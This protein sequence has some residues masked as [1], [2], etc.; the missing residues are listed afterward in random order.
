MKKK[1]KQATPEQKIVLKILPE[2]FIVTTSFLAEQFHTTT[3]TIRWK[4]PKRIDVFNL[5]A[6]L[7]ILSDNLQRL[8]KLYQLEGAQVTTVIPNSLSP[9]KVVAIPLNLNTSA[10]KKEY[11]ALQK[12]AY[13]F[14]KEYDEGLVDIKD[15]Q[16]R[17]NF[18]AFNDNDGSSTMLYT[19]CSSK[20]I[21]EYASM[22]LGG[23]LYPIAFI[24]EDQSIIRIVESRL[25]RVERERPFC[26]FYLTKGNSRLIYVNN[27]V[28][29]IAKVDISDMDEIL[30]DELPEGDASSAINSDL[31]VDDDTDNVF[32]SEVTN[33][34]SGNLK[35]AFAFL[36]DELKATKV[37]TVFFISDHN[38]E[39]ILFQL[40]R[41]NFRLANFRSLNE[42]F[43]FIDLAE[44]QNN[45]ANEVIDKKEGMANKVYGSFML[46][47]LGC[48]AMQYFSTPAY[49]N[50][51]IDTPL[52]NLHPKHNFIVRNF[53]FFNYFK[54]SRKIMSFFLILA[55]IFFFYTM[56]TDKTKI[57]AKALQELTSAQSDYA[58]AAS[59]S[60]AKKAAKMKLI[61]DIA[62][63]DGL[64]KGKHNE[65]LFN[66]INSELPT[67]L[68][69]ERVAIRRG[70]FVLV[71]NG[72]S[73]S[74]VNR[75]YEKVLSNIDFKDIL[76]L[77]VFKRA[78]N[79]LNY[80]EIKGNVQ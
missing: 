54:I 66:F 62:N 3:T 42:H 75:F 25:T 71:G 14:W 57:K 1:N 9:M 80:F 68:E 17:S 36:K 56:A 11:A 37:E 5:N 46:P 70:S 13:E 12:Q 15:A 74:E 22:I 78:D 43:D 27:N 73:I 26:V 24:P 61:K 52:F 72:K 8:A 65:K 23:N 48:Y 33:R 50:M 76:P 16:I 2:E 40:F 7:E 34:L 51:V 41:K 67:D 18:L 44:M 55:V 39:N 47:N 20:I 10:D 60:A 35:Q 21:M 45:S 4:L 38:K 6:D 31:A 63:I 32:W 59:V 79:Q 69:L 28:V 77:K 19:A 49:K 30:F 53:K 58:N 64:I 29:Y